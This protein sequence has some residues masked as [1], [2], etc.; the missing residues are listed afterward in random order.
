MMKKKYSLLIITV[1][2]S[3]LF[4]SCF[5]NFT[6]RAYYSA[7]VKTFYFAKQDTC[8]DIENYVFNIDQLTDTGQ[9]Y[10]L[11]SLPYGRKV[12]HLLPSLSLETSN[13]NVYMN[14]S[15]WGDKAA[16]D[17][18]SFNFP[19]LLKNTSSDDLY[20]RYY[21][22]H[23][24]V[25]QVDPDSMNL[26]KQSNIF[27]TDASMNRMLLP[28]ENEK[29]SFRNYF[30]LSAGGMSAHSS[31]N[32][33]LTWT[34]QTIT[35]INDNVNLYSLCKYNSIYY[36]VSKAGQLYR[37]QD[38]L[39]WDKVKD[40][41]NNVVKTKLITLF[42]QIKRKYITEKDS[43]Y[44]IGL[45][46]S[47]GAIYPVRSV[48]GVNWTYGSSAVSSE[49]PIS[50]GASIKG[51]TVTGV[52]FYT[53]ATGLK[54]D[55]RFCTSVWS[56]ENGLDWVSIHDWDNNAKPPVQRKGASLFFYNDTL[57]CF[58]GVDSTGVYCKDFHVSADCGLGW[59][60]A[61][62]SW[63]FHNS[64]MHTGLAYSSVYVE[65]KPGPVYNNKDNKDSEFIWIFGGSSSNGDVSSDIWRA[66]LNKMIFARW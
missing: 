51:T 26:Y 42:G 11:D 30:A 38:G 8:P 59:A 27:P 12:D 22:I 44:L 19:V 37:S 43:I 21:R 5:D 39:S 53:V 62:Y 48:D 47:L 60:E 23:V 33:G 20:T 65:H 34:S 49:F 7:N 4:V 63:S 50:E 36:V 2:F 46:D 56:T 25:H 3:G 13:D 17:T 40:A 35:G 41:S 66:Y 58:G 57:V 14:D 1:I 61:P 52:E 18:I 32:G 16:H 64:V 29:E 55:G 15:I 45:A 24:N 28:D 9:I 31:K 6:E 10:N 54:A